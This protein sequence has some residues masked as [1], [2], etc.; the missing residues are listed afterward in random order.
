[1]TPFPAQLET[2]NLEEYGILELQISYPGQHH[3]LIELLKKDGDIA[4]RS[5]QEN[6]TD[7]TNV[8]L[9]FL[10]PEVY[11]LRVT[12]DENKN[13]IWDTGNFMDKKQPEPI[14]FYPAEIKLRP[15]WSY[16]VDFKLKH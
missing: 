5:Y 6:H 15:N 7:T 4:A 9:E 3:L 13:G 12:V 1:M 14:Y 16:G 8:N 2:R 10:L 11:K